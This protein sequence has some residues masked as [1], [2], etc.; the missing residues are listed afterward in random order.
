M[1]ALAQMR[2]LAHMRALAQIRA[3]AHMRAL[4]RTDFSLQ[5]TTLAQLV[6]SYCG[7]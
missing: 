3:L 4:A 5:H 7:I 1:R 2:A 6:G